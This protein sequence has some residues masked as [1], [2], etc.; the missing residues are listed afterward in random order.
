MSDSRKNLAAELVG[1]MPASDDRRM[2]REHFATVFEQMA[3]HDDLT[4]L[5]D[6]KLTEEAVQHFYFFASRYPDLFGTTSSE[7]DFKAIVIALSGL[8][9][10]A[11]REMFREI[12]RALRQDGKAT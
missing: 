9:H 10:G 2:W 1:L 7:S 12:A 3:E 8:E 11:R 6:A 4:I 5:T